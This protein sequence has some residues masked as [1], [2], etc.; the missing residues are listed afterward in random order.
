V[1][2]FREDWIMNDA[3]TLHAAFINELQ[4]AYDAEQQLA[5]ALPMLANAAHSEDLRTAFEE[6]LEETRGHVERLEA[7]FE[8]LDETVKGKHCEGIAGIIAEGSSVLSAD[9]DEATMDAVLI[10]AG[11]RAEHYE[12]AAYSTLIAWARAMG[13]TE[14]ADLLR[15]TLREERSAD[16]RLSAIGE[17]GINQEA[18]DSAHA[19]ESDEAQDEK[20]DRDVVTER[21]TGRSKRAG[22][23]VQQGKA[24]TSQ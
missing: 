14:A 23:G 21:R 19:S 17:G 6:H 8:S 1:P 11:Q 15:E 5:K 4:D 3:G 18:A 9:F 13:H 24:H 22:R 7:V 16:E 20:E 2:S 10:A 12:M